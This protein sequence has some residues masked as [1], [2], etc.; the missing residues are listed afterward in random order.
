MNIFELDQVAN[1]PEVEN[2]L[3][4][5]CMNFAFRFKHRGKTDF[6]AEFLTTINSFASSYSARTVVLLADKKYSKYRKNLDEGYK[7]GRKDKYKDQTDEEKAQVEAFFEGYEKALELAESQYPLLRFAYVE[8]DDTAAYLVKHISHKFEHTWLISSDG[9]WDLLLR[10]DVSRFSF[11]TRKEYTLDNFYEL[12]GCDSPEQYIS[13]K[14]LQGDSGDSVQGIPGVGAKRAYG[15]VREYGTA[16]DLYDQLPIVGKQKMIQKINESGELI[17]LNY[18]LMDL[19]AYCDDAIAFP[20][21]NNLKIM[22]EF[23][24]ECN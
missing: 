22:E 3:I 19:L 4:V 7:G 6:A 13:V 20:D 11:V 16:L 23:C 24:N 5:D 17:L 12:H 10:D 8:A 18:E 21:E 14:V 2:L 15:L 1:A 9:D